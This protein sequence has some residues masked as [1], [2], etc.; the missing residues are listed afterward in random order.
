MK[1]IIRRALKTTYRVHPKGAG[2]SVGVT[3]HPDL[4]FA[5]GETVRFVQLLDSK[6][7]QVGVEIE[8]VVEKAKKRIR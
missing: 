5:T 6:G 7:A 4:G 8:R 3:L 1:D 2:G